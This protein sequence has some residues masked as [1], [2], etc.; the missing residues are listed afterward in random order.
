MKA[1][2][3]LREG[4]EAKNEQADT[5]V[6]AL[7]D[8]FSSL[9]WVVVFLGLVILWAALA[10][11]LYGFFT[12]LFPRTRRRD[13]SN[14]IVESGMAIALFLVLSSPVLLVMDSF[15]LKGILPRIAATVLL[16]IGTVFFLWLVSAKRKAGS[17]PRWDLKKEGFFK[18][19]LAVPVILLAYVPVHLSV[20]VAWRLCLVGLGIEAQMQEVLT[21]PLKEGG[22]SLLLVFASAV[23]A[24][25]VLEEILFRGALYRALRENIGVLPGAFVSAAIFSLCHR[26][27]AGFLPLLAFAVLLAFAYEWTGSL[28]ASIFLHALFNFTNFALA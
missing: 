23:T 28:W 12:R 20:V 25:P 13:P 1:V 26:N 27:V 3:F 11:V 22:P 2:I 7:T 21:E 4:L 14:T 6:R 18:I 9:D 8:R 17:F 19:A 24:V 10:A 5:M 16:Q 15:G